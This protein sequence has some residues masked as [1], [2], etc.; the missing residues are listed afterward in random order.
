MDIDFVN[1]GD[2]I[3]EEDL[4][5]LLSKLQ[6]IGEELLQVVTAVDR[7]NLLDAIVFPATGFHDIPNQC[8]DK[9][10]TIAISHLESKIILILVYLMDAQLHSEAVNFPKTGKLVILLSE[11]CANTF[12][13][14]TEKDDK[15]TY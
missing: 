7:K 2:V 12:P 13:D 1:R 10:G 14:F 3:Y 15:P 9:L 11:L 4:I 8:I 6:F 5:E